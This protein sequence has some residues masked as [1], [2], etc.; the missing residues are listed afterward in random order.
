[1]TPSI[2]L[3]GDILRVCRDAG[4][5]DD[6][7]AATWLRA[8]LPTAPFTAVIVFRRVSETQF[9]VGCLSLD[10]ELTPA[11]RLIAGK[12]PGDPPERAPRV[13]IH[14]DGPLPAAVRLFRSCLMREKFAGCTLDDIATAAREQGFQE[15]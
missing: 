1:M 2:D 14:Q 15:G 7:H 10:G 11:L 13:M 12:L 4:M 8:N 6:A 3:L 5:P 9:T